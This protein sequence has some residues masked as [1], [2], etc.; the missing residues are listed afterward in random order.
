MFKIYRTKASF[1]YI[2]KEGLH[3]SLKGGLKNEITARHDIHYLVTLVE[4][5]KVQVTS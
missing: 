3:K 2:L 5:F 4:I 1:I